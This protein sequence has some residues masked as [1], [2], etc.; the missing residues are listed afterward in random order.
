MDTIA[1]V[2]IIIGAA[3]LIIL[4]VHLRIV[5][6]GTAVVVQRLGKYRKTLDTGLH[7]LFP[8][9]D[10]TLPA[11]SLKE[12]VADFKPSEVITKDNV[13]M[14]IDS[15]VFFQVV[16]P[17]QVIALAAHGVGAQ[18]RHL[19]QRGQ[20][21]PLDHELRR[22]KAAGQRFGQRHHAAGKAVHD[23]KLAFVHL[24]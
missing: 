1:I 4:A 12:Q 6:Q 7:L 13:K 24:T 5:K 8:F 11:I 15:I 16:D 3:L 2:A 20:R 22:V 17:K 18:I 9:I 19:E 23:L 10:R 21:V 14:L